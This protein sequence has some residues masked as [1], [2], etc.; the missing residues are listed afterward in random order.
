MALQ[1]SNKRVVEFY[2]RHSMVSFEEVNVF[3]VDIL[4]K[5]IKDNSPSLLQ[6]M[7]KTILS[8]QTK[9]DTMSSDVSKLQNETQ[10]TLSLKMMERIGCLIL[11]SSLPIER[12]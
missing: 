4:E 1:I 2:K 12:F 11:S 8:L 6:E 10:T 7:N 5:M 9:M 3:M